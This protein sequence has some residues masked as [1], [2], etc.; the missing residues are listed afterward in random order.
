MSK[1]ES[2]IE[3]AERISKILGFYN[4]DSCLRFLERHERERK[5]DTE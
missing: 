3:E 2:T 4:F 5:N 1:I